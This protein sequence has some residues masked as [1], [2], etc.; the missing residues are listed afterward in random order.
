[1][2]LLLYW[3]KQRFAVELSV[4]TM[5]NRRGTA[6]AKIKNPVDVQQGSFLLIKFYLSLSVKSAL[7]P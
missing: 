6:G 7:G 5:L 4:A 3:I 2:A 1:M